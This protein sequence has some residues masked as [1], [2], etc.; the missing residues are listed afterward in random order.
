VGGQGLAVLSGDAIKI[1]TRGPV[2]VAGRLSVGGLPLGAGCR[3][4]QDR[5]PLPP[6]AGHVTRVIFPVFGSCTGTVFSPK[7]P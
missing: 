2:L 6:H 4:T 7:Q 3:V 1:E 5:V